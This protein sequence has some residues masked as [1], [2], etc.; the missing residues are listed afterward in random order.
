MTN[1]QSN[2]IFYAVISLI[3]S[4]LLINMFA[5]EVIQQATDSKEQIT[6]RKSLQE[7]EYQTALANY[8]TLVNSELE[9]NKNTIEL[10]NLY[11]EIAQ[12]QRQLGNS[13]EENNYY[14]KSLAI[15]KSL[16]KIDIFSLAKTYYQLGIIAEQS[17]QLNQAQNY[18]EKALTT[19]L[20]VIVD[21]K[22]EDLGMFDGMQ[23][24][25]LQY[26]R[27]NNE[28]TIAN[29]LKLANIHKLKEQQAIAKEYYDKALAASI[30]TFGEDDKRTLDL[31][32][33]GL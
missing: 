30:L 13:V 21:L 15:K 7:G 1:R 31:K 26:Q 24:S 18:F 25:R 20:G 32:N 33:N 28:G 17:E 19:R 29:Y 3:M 4:A 11:E 9:N 6:I 16:K 5:P 12:V 22:E 23:Q 8:E 27:L 10:A 14:L 2:I